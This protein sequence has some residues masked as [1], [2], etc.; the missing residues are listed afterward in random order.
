MWRNVGDYTEL[1]NIDSNNEFSKSEIS[2]KINSV[3]KETE[4]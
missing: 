1:K 4:Y 3:I 2:D